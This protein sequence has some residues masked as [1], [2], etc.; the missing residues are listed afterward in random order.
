MSNNEFKFHI[1]I[2]ERN[3][4]DKCVDDFANHLGSGGVE[5]HKLANRTT[6][7]FS[8]ANYTPDEQD[9]L[10]G[11]EAGALNNPHPSTH[12]YTMITG[13]S[14]VGHSGLFK[15]LLDIP[16]TC[17]IAEKGNCNTIDGIRITLGANAPEN[18]INDKELWFDTSSK[19]IKTYS[20]N[21]WVSF[22]AV[23]A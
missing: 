21:T 5:N 22:S 1:S 18:P 20:G 19:L 13:L 23:W 7:G 15:D 3:K 2:A 9:K 11:I 4:W 14:I 17:F 8:Q 10:A 12:P 6:A 16:S